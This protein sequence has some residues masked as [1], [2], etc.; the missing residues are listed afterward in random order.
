ERRKDGQQ[1]SEARSH[2]GAAPADGELPARKP[3]YR[4]WQHNLAGAWRE[5]RFRPLTAGVKPFFRPQARNPLP[6]RGSG[7]LPPILGRQGRDDRGDYSEAVSAF[8][9]TATAAGLASLVF[10]SSS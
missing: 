3:E 4:C 10:C 8:R 5:A 9:V 2:Q 1:P 7:W 6:L